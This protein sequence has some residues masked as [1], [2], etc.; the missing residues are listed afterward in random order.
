MSQRERENSQN[1]F[2][3]INSSNKWLT[4]FF[5]SYHKFAI[6]FL[7]LNDKIV[8]YSKHRRYIKSF[9]NVWQIAE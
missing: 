7:S 2:L 3:L 5:A 8:C 9:V 6:T 4:C 1:K